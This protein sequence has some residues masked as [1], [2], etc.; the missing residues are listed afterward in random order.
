M[1]QKKVQIQGAQILSDNSYLAYFEKTRNAAQ[2]RIWTFYEA[3]N[4]FLKKY[5]YGGLR[6]QR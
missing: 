1:A 5:C 6:V 3:V 4:Y 2:H